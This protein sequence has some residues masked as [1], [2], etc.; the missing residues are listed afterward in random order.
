M[1][2]VINSYIYVNVHIYTVDAEREREREIDDKWK[3][4]LQQSQDK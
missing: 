2:N 4:T 1:K 3:R